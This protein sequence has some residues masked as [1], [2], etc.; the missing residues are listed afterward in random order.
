MQGRVDVHLDQPHV[1]VCVD[2]EVEAVQLKEANPR[3]QLV[4]DGVENVQH[5][6]L[7]LSLQKEN[8][9]PQFMHE[10]FSSSET[11]IS[12]RNFKRNA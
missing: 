8:V 1:H 3:S 7:D 9:E 4:A 6:A 12:T 10:A 11:G 2:H 5:N